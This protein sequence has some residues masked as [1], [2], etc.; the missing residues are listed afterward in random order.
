MGGGAASAAPPM[1]RPSNTDIAYRRFIR[2]PP[3]GSVPRTLLLPIGR[4]ICLFCRPR[5]ALSGMIYVGSVT[6]WHR[7]LPGFNREGFRWPPR[8]ENAAR[9]SVRREV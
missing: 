3:D 6:V 7:G 8:V 2:L 4:G 5:T 9:A 1:P